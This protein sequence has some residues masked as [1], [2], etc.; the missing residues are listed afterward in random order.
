MRCLVTDVV[1]WISLALYTK[2]E[3]W[4]TQWINWRF[5]SSARYTFMLDAFGA[6]IKRCICA[7]V[8]VFVQCAETSVWTTFKLSFFV[9]VVVFVYLIF[10][11]VPF[12]HIWPLMIAVFCYAYFNNDAAF[13]DTRY[14]GMG[15][16][17][18]S[19]LFLIILL[20]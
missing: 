8:C 15:N 7:C 10:T 12:N 6:H 3:R 17:D 5:I 20:N 9:A 18:V 4:W 11:H 13:S 2:K 14:I 16:I 1:C 19:S